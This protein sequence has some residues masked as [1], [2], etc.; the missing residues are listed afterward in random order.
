MRS[1][2][3]LIGL[4][5]ALT[6]V[7]A[8]AGPPYLTDDPVPADPGHW[9]VFA[10][11][12]GEGRHS[13]F[14]GDAGLDVNFGAMKD[15]QLT[16]TVP[17]SFAHDSLE[18]WSSGTGD[19]EAGVKYQFLHDED[20]GISAAVFPRLIFPTADHS[21]GEKVRF[22]L[23]LWTQKDFAGGTS[24]FGGGGYTINPGEGNR[25]FW[26]AGIA[27]TQDVSKS[28]SVGA[29]ITQQGSDTKDGTAQTRAGFGTIIIAPFSFKPS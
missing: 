16:A 2:R 26:Q 12:S 5:S 7:P 21:P 19:L 1:V 3:W 6:S 20:H 18:G 11:A 4:A 23:P 9:E 28:F 29:E 15:V 13:D 22:L 8:L 14:D 10:F 17:L 27:V 25:D 24:M